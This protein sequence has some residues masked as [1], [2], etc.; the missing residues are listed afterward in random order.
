MYEWNGRHGVEVVDAPGDLHCPVCD[1]I[2]GHRPTLLQHP[3]QRAAPRVLHD[4]TQ[5]G[6]QQAH[7]LEGDDVLVL[8]QP[9][10]LGLLPHVLHHP[11]QG[12]VRVVASSLDRHLLA[13]P[14]PAVDLK[15]AGVREG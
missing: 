11:L 4:Q 2:G 1:H 7:A 13:P 8:E 9:E 12:L 3:A 10:E 5:V 15:E 6:L 14:R